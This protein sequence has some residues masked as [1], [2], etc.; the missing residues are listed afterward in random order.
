[1]KL[2]PDPAWEERDSELLRKKNRSRAWWRRPLIP[3]LR[4][5]RQAD[6]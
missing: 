1:M 4:R 3:T 2:R 5:Q 6:F